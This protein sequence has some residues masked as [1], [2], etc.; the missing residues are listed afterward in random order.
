MSFKPVELRVLIKTLEKSTTR[1]HGKEY[2]KRSGVCSLNWTDDMIYNRICGDK[3]LAA[4]AALALLLE[5]N[6]WSKN[7]LSKSSLLSKKKTIKL[8][9]KFHDCKKKLQNERTF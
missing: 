4:V 7:N 3:E 9:H 2:D 1:H 6:D 8:T 5:F